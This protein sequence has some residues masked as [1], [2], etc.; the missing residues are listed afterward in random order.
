MPVGTERLAVHHRDAYCL[1]GVDL[2]L[3]L[4]SCCD[5]TGVV[6]R[7]QGSERV[8]VPQVAPGLLPCGCRHLCRCSWALTRH[9]PKCVLLTVLLT[10]Q[11]RS[12]M[13]AFATSLAQR[14][15]CQALRWSSLK[16]KTFAVYIFWCM[17]VLTLSGL[18]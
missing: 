6:D 15:I 9:L 18:L 11:K 8:A 16:S 7:A 14:C 12:R 3:F 10:S 4:I 17:H 13:Q 5:C 1:A 2:F